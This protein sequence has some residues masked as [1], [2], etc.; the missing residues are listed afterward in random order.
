ML[1]GSNPLFGVHDFDLIKPFC[2]SSFA[3]KFT[4]EISVD[5]EQQMAI[6]VCQLKQP[7]NVV[8]H[9]VGLVLTMFRWRGASTQI[10]KI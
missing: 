7:Q 2:F 9:K 4:F 10:K 8:D 1:T 5:A 3:P 6:G